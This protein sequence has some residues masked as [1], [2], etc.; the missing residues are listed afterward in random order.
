[1]FMQK[2]LYVK[3]LGQKHLDTGMDSI[4]RIGGEAKSDS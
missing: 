4:R 3:T 1:M 2:P